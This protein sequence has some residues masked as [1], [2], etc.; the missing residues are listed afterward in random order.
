M[1]QSRADDARFSSLSAV[2]ETNSFNWRSAFDLEQLTGETF[3][4]D[5]RNLQG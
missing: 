3:S 2:D 4:S 5:G 1:D